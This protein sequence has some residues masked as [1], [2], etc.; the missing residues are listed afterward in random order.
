MNSNSVIGVVYSQ[1]YHEV[2][3]DSLVEYVLRKH[4]NTHLPLTHTPLFFS[5]LFID[6]VSR[7]DGTFVPDMNKVL[8]L[9]ELYSNSFM[10][11][12][13]LMSDVLIQDFNT[14]F[15]ERLKNAKGITTFV[16]TDITSTKEIDVLKH[17]GATILYINDESGDADTSTLRAFA[18]HIYIIKNNPRDEICLFLESL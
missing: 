1:R 2:I 11:D 18:D 9:R 14:R 13:R 3:K 15:S 12:G 17:A 8:K 7:I 10:N 6:L 5:K 4:N 16:V